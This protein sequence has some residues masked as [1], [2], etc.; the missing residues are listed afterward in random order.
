MSYERTRV[1]LAF[2]I[3]SWD[4]ALAHLYA[5]QQVG[6]R[7][8]FGVIG[9]MESEL[10]TLVDQWDT[11]HGDFTVETPERGRV[12]VVDEARAYVAEHG[13]ELDDYRTDE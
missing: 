10:R 4:S 11:T 9:R 3:A 5:L 13:D 8:P 1:L 6:E 2:G 7:V 12:R